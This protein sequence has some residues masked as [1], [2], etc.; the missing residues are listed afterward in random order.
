MDRS[1]RKTLGLGESL[2]TLAIVLVLLQTFLED[3][4][5]VLGWSWPIRRVLV[6]T[7]LFF[8]VFF[9]VEFV[10]RYVA[11]A[12]Q[13]TAREYFLRG[14]GWIDFLASVPLLVLNSGP[15]ALSVLAGA[16]TLGSVGSLLSVLK[17]VKIIRITRILRLLRLLKFSARIKSIQSPMAQRHITRIATLVLYTLIFGNILFSSFQAAVGFKGLDLVLESQ[18]NSLGRDLAD[19][20]LRNQVGADYAANL[21]EQTPILLMVRQDDRIVYSRYSPE[22]LAQKYGPNDYA[23]AE[24][25]NTE[26]YIDLLPYHAEAAAGN[27]QIFLLYAGLTLL[28]IFG[29]GTHFTRTVVDPMQIMT[30]GM[31]EE[32]YQMRVSIPPQYSGDEVY[33]LARAYNTGHLLLKEERKFHGLDDEPE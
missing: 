8:D 2:L 25:E 18:A 13:G 32:G 14:H 3:F 26:V 31:S 30:R 9:T 7:G 11:A 16:T 27:L 20:N 5:I 15:A 22:Q 23:R 10:L 6:F 21:A 12:S 19:R 24:L 1:N 17:V 28:L 33:D 4:S 29:Y